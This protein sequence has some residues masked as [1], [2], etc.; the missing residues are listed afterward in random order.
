MLKK[1]LIGIAII[2]A[3]I[4]FTRQTASYEQPIIEQT[5]L[6]V[7]YS[8][9][10]MYALSKVRAEFGLGDWVY[11]NDLLNRESG[12]NYLAANPTSSARGLC[13]TMMSIHDTPYGFLQDPY[14]QIDWCVKYVSDT[15]GNSRNAILFHNKNNWF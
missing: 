7:D 8:S 1:I 9:V 5:A 12:W 14:M 2:L 11:F 15:Y 3:L 6:K 13:Q 10:Q 4:V